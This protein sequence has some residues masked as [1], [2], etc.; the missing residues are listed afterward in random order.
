MPQSPDITVVVCTHNRAESLRQALASL[1]ALETGGRFTYEVLVID[2]ASSDRTAEVI[3]AAAQASQAPLRGVHEPQK[4]IVAARNRGVL[5]AAGKWIAFFDDDQLADRRWLLEL[6]YAAE[7]HIVCSVGGAVHLQLPS[8]C[9]RQLAPLVRTLLGESRW[10]ETAT[11]YTRSTSPGAGN[12]LLDRSLVLDVGMFQAANQGR[13]EDSDLYR[14][15]CLAGESSWFVPAAIVHHIITPDRLEEAY[16]LRLA[17][18]VGQFVAAREFS[19]DGRAKHLLLWLLKGMRAGLVYYPHWLLAR[20]LGWNEKALDLRCL[21]EIQR[22]YL[23]QGWT[24]LTSRAPAADKSSAEHRVPP[25]TLARRASEGI[26][27]GTA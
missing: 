4:G 21:L 8:G 22:A 24:L 16:L 6:Y 5:E 15:L 7:E 19:L 9:D 13:N 12:W 10:S 3:A 25:L 18:I 17:R 20:L 11:P 23:A 27:R 2:N 26:T 1:Y 14:R